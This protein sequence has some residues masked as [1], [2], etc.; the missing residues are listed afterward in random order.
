[1]PDASSGKSRLMSAVSD[2]SD[3]L[4][5]NAIEVYVSR[6]RANS[7]RRRASAPCAAWDIASMRQANDPR[8]D[9]PSIRR[10]LLALLLI[11][12]PRSRRRQPTAPTA[13]PS[14]PSKPPTTRRCWMRHWPCQQYR[15]ARRFGATLSLTPDAV[16]VLRSD[17]LDTIYYRFQETMA[18][19]SPAIGICPYP[20]RVSRTRN[21]TT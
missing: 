17:S 9:R 11:P 10:R 5:P 16:T 12:L 1:M 14:P 21:S 18:T 20:T 3:D 19:S 4:S 7:V 2:W 15:G 13:P 6:L 8:N